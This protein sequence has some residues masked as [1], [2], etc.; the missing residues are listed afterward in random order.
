MKINGRES[1]DNAC[2]SFDGRGIF[3]IGLSRARSTNIF[4]RNRACIDAELPK[5][6]LIAAPK[7][8]RERGSRARYFS[9]CE[10]AAGNYGTATLRRSSPFRNTMAFEKGE[11]RS[12]AER[13]RKAR[14]RIK[15]VGRRSFTS[16]LAVYLPLSFS[17]LSRWWLVI[18]QLCD[19]LSSYE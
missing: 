2:A 15:V 5:R 16:K 10:T 11:R 9:F 19:I 3:R 1:K 18:G 14:G 17:L 4:V 13:G 8:Q 6:G 7:R 12:E